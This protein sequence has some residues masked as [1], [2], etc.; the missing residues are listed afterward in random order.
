[1]KILSTLLVIGI[2]LSCVD[3]KA[4]E[5]CSLGEDVPERVRFQ[6]IAVVVF[7][8]PQCFGVYENGQLSS[9][10]LKRELFGLVSTGRLGYETPT[11]D[12]DKGP[13]RVNRRSAD[14]VSNEFAL[15]V[16]G[17]LQEAPMPFAQFIDEEGRALHAGYVREKF[18]SHGCIR[19]PIRAAEALFYGFEQQSLQVIV[20]WNRG[21]FVSLWEEGHFGPK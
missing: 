2:I 3:A 6:G 17:V 18:A 8:E 11:T 5:R 7:L 15:R 13:Q 21:D 1:M 4:A 10:Y 16:D 9:R 20:V 19:L 14:H 12:P